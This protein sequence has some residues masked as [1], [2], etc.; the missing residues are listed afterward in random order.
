MTRFCL[1]C[2]YVTRIIEPLASRCAKFRFRAL[3][4]EPMLT[5]LRFIAREEDVSCFGC[6]G[7]VRLT[8]VPAPLGRSDQSQLVVLTPSARTRHPPG[9]RRNRQ[10]TAF[11]RRL[12]IGRIPNTAPLIF[13]IV[14]FFPGL[15]ASHRNCFLRCEVQPPGTLTMVGLVA[16]AWMTRGGFNTATPPS[17]LPTRLA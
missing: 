8:R 11:V 4:R 17:H 2:N 13:G 10:P 3:G 6:T 5:R 1:I 9:F 15:L 7:L 14:I 16:D 12:L